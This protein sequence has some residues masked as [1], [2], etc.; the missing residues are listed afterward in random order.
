[1]TLE[2]LKDQYSVYKFVPEYIIS[3]NILSDEFYSITKTKDELSVVAKTNLFNDFLEAE[4][5]WRILKIKG[6]LDFNLIGVISK[7]SS[8]LADVNISIFVVSTFNTD[9]IMIKSEN[10]EKTVDVLINNKYEIQLH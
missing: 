4:N 1:M 7:I 5:G 8:L 9:Y 3:E 6:L 2:L 10:L